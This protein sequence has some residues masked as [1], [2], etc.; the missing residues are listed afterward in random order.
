MMSVSH[1]HLAT[2]KHVMAISSQQ[3]PSCDDLHLLLNQLDNPHRYYF[4]VCR[5]SALVHYLQHLQ[6]ATILISPD[7]MALMSKYL[8]HLA[9]QSPSVFETATLECAQLALFGSGHH[10]F[11][12]PINH[13]TLHPL[14]SC[15][16]PL[17][18]KRIIT[19]QGH[20]LF[21]QREPCVQ[22]NNRR[23]LIKQLRHYTQCINDN[24]TPWCQLTLTDCLGNCSPSGAA[25][26]HQH[27]SLALAPV[28]LRFIEHLTLP[29]WQAIITA[30]HQRQPL[31]AVIPPLFIDGDKS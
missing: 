12:W 4:A 29:Q 21:C 5:D 27:H 25:V 30:L 3:P 15:T 2:I 23:E 6:L 9:V 18:A 24:D 8:T 17:K 19:S 20:I 7:S 14:I 22:T 1:M 31:A 28:R 13:S 16:I 26:I 11:N 10:R